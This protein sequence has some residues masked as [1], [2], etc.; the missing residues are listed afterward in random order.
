MIQSGIASC[1]SALIEGPPFASTYPSSFKQFPF[2]CHD[3]A[4]EDSTTAL[5]C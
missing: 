4:A 1:A 2:L 5:R 3:P